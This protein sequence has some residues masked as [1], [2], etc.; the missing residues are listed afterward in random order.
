MG[1]I[2][3]RHNLRGDVLDLNEFILARPGMILN[4]R[5]NNRPGPRPSI[6]RARRRRGLNKELL[7]SRANQKPT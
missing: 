2:K 5:E 3:Q 7:L 4:L 6:G 1:R